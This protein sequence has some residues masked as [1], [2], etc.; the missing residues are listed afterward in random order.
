MHNG[1]GYE[2]EV[3]GRAYDRR[4]VARLWIY[5]RPYRGLIALTVALFPFIAGVELIQPYLIKVA[6]DQHI[7]KGDWPGLAPVAGFF[8]LALVGQYLFRFW[9]VYVMNLTGQRVTHDLRLALFSHVQKLDARFFDRNPVGRV[10]TR[11]VND[12]EAINEMFSA[13]VVAILGD[14]VTLLGVVAVMLWMDWRLALVTF[15][16]IPALF[17]VAFF[18]RLR[19]RDAYRA[20]RTRIARLNAFLQENLQGLTVVKLFVRER[21]HLEEFKAIN[22]EYRR[23]LFTSMTFDSALYAIVEVIGFLATALLLWY[24]GGQIIREALTFGVLVAFLEYTHRFFL[25]IRDL[26][27]KYAVMQSAMASGERIFTLLD[28]APAVAPPAVARRPAA[29][30]GRVEFDGVWFAYQGEEWVLRDLSFRVEPGRRVALVGVTGAGKSTIAKLLN[31]SYDVQRGRVLVDGIDVREWDLERLRRWV[32]EVSQDVFL[33]SGSV[34]ENLRLATPHT[35]SDRLQEAARLANA[36]RFIRSLP[37]GY[38]ELLQERGANLSQGQRQ[39]LAIARTLVYDPAVLVMDEATSS[40]DSETEAMIQEALE[41]LLAS[42]TSLVIAHR[43][44][45]VQQADRIL[46]LHKGRLR[47]EGS[48]QALMARGGLYSR[49]YELQFG[50]G[51]RGHAHL[52]ESV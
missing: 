49:L 41:H 37:K 48:H 24:G 33:F 36:D 8:L 40:V 13:G 47:E 18:F 15:S 1:G 23:A 43:L 5:V 9:Q 3:L 26:S 20:V 14:A 42:R 22:G 17:A 35:I 29:L 12:V 16:V 10:M 39:L 2:D 21:A 44:S 30:A 46:V 4:L 25:P 11:V 28:T 6:I 32:G 38:D 52:R 50:N 19:A 27:A 31:R 34:A 51:P 7:L 45:T